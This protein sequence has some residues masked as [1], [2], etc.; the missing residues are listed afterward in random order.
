MWGMRSWIPFAAG[1]QRRKL[2][3]QMRYIYTS[4]WLMKQEGGVERLS[5]EALV[6]VK[7]IH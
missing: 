3:D 4:D 2:T 5:Q 7:T 1:R 6:E